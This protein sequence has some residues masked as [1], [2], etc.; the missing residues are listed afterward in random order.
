MKKE[1]ESKIT[2][3][4]KIAPKE[5][6]EETR[7]RMTKNTSMKKLAS[8]IDEKK[9]DTLLVPFLKIF[10]K[11]KNIFTSSSCAGRIMLL[12]A[13]EYEH[14]MP[15]MFAAKWHRNVKTNEIWNVLQ[16][17]YDYPEIWF[18]Q[19]SYIFHF[20]CKDLDVAKKVLQL[21][22]KFGIRRGGIFTIDDGRYIIEL[23]GSNNMSLPVKYG[24]KILLT[25][26]QIDIIVKKANQKLTKNYK[27]LKEL[28]KIF[29]KEL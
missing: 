23:I 15:N 2:K 10:N 7:F 25:K 6:L 9:A 19:E 26:D 18:K 5:S 24:K 8:A 4:P 12:G 20:V 14:K 17:D 21:K 16:K 11:K 22:N 1:T 28:M 29:Q 27:I 3:K 13:D